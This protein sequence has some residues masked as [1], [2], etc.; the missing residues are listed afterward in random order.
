MRRR[1]ES[2]NRSPASGAPTQDCTSPPETVSFLSENFLRA[3]ILSE[4]VFRRFDLV[5]KCFLEALILFENVS[6]DGLIWF[7][8]VFRRFCFVRKCFFRRFDLVRKCFQMLQFCPKLF[9]N[10]SVVF[11]TRKLSDYRR[12]Q[13]HFVISS[14]VDITQRFSIVRYQPQCFGIH[15]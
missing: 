9:L 15:R 2:R 6:L 10:T 7:E 11:S 8:N 5:R 1:R 4:N 3:S 12:H 14:V 13:V